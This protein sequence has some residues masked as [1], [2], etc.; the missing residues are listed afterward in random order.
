MYSPLSEL[1][2]MAFEYGYS[3]E[4]PNHLV[5]WEAQFGDFNNGAQIVIDQVCISKIQFLIFF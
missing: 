4:N 2:A 3:W 5:L 1:A